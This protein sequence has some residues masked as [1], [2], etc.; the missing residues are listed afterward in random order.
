MEYHTPGVYIRE[1]DSGPRP[2]ASVATSVPGFLGLFS[3]EPPGRRG[4]DPGHGRREAAA[5]QGRPAAGRHAQGRSTARHRRGGDRAC[6]GVQAA[7]HGRQGRQGAARDGGPQVEH[8]EVRVRRRRRS[9]SASRA[10]RSTRRVLDVEGKVV[11]DSEQL[12]DEMLN[13]VHAAFP[14]D[15]PRPKTAKDLLVD[16]RVRVP[17]REG[18]LAHERV[19]GAAV[20]GDEQE[21]VLPAGSRATSRSTAWRPG[22][23]RSSSAAKSRTPTMRPTPSSRPSRPTTPS[24]RTSG[25]GCRSPRCSTSSPR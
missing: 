8:R 5:G 6:R 16:L 17:G 12:V 15:K 1:V 10:S 2:I 23:S 14:I 19:L 24:R 20:R 13:A 9:R 21:R 4:R 7:P 22:P 3:H 18:H 25:S 11:T